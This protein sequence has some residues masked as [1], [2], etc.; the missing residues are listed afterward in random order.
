MVCGNLVDCSF[1]NI[2]IGL[3]EHNLRSLSDVCLNNAMVRNSLEWS[4][5]CI[6]IWM[7]VPCCEIPFVFVFHRGKERQRGLISPTPMVQQQQCQCGSKMVD[8][9]CM[10]KSAQFSCSAV[11]FGLILQFMLCHSKYVWLKT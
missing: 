9:V 7:F 11:K 1:I 10:K 6:C 2:P 3:L 5:C 4:Y 8:A